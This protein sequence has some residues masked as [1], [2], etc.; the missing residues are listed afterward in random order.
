MY[1]TWLTLRRLGIFH[2]SP[3]VGVVAP[4]LRI[5]EGMVILY[6]SQVIK[7]ILSLQN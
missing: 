3:L 4:F 7:V 2:N 6:F 1:C 5:S